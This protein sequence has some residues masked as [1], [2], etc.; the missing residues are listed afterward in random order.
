MLMTDGY[1][2]YNGIAHAQQLVHRMLGT[3]APRLHQTRGVGTE[4]CTLA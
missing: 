2:L 4:G 1:E 3:R